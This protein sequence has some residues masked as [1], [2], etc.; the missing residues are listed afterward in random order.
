M[1]TDHIVSTDELSGDTY[2][3]HEKALL[4]LAALDRLKKLEQSRDLLSEQDWSDRLG[5]E[6]ELQQARPLLEKNVERWAAQFT[7]EEI[8]QVQKMDLLS[9]EELKELKAISAKI[10]LQKHREHGK[11]KDDFSYHKW[12]I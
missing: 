7:P 5:T 11:G 1:D 4:F 2:S 10:E 9:T 3:L 8:A 6:E 12:Q